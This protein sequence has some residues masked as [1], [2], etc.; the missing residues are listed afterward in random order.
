MTSNVI[1]SARRTPVGRF[2]GGFSRVPSPQLGA[3]AVEA[4]LASAGVDAADVDECIMGCVLQAG[5]G[6]NPARQAALKGGL[7]VTVSAQTINKV[8]GSGLQ[9]VMS[10]WR[11]SRSKL[12][13]VEFIARVASQ[14]GFNC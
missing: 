7:P 4:A 2:L 8:C 14:T 11:V 3:F 13:A 10:V 5:L 12:G 9:A 1:L 6:Q